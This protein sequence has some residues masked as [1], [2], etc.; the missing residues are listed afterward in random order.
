MEFLS[1]H[2]GGPGAPEEKSLYRVMPV[3]LKMKT[4]LMV[5]ETMVDP[6]V[7]KKGWNI[8]G[9]KDITFL[10]RG[11]IGPFT[12]CQQDF[13]DFLFQLALLNVVIV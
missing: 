2:D 13:T 4:F 3:T 12:L 5:I 7:Q 11:I 8:P 9:V 10:F 1:F 6:S